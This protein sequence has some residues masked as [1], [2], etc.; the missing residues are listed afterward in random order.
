MEL[1][2]LVQDPCSFSL[3]MPSSKPLY[4]TSPP[5]SCTVGLGKNNN[6]CLA[7]RT[8]SHVQETG[9]DIRV[10]LPYSSIQQFFDHRNHFIIVIWWSWKDKWRFL[11]I[12]KQLALPVSVLRTAQPFEIFTCIHT[13]LAVLI[14]NRKSGGE[15][16]HNS[17]EYIG[18]NYFP[19]HICIRLNEREWT[20]VIPGNDSATCHTM[21]Y[22]WYRPS[23][24]FDMVIKSGPR[25]TPLTPS[26]LNS[27]LRKQKTTLSSVLLCFVRHKVKLEMFFFLNLG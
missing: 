19:F 16:V 13:R 22:T 1:G 23:C 9:A 4:R 20:E 5:S 8:Q 18:L 27:C 11:G 6:T 2:Q 25:S 14:D 3:T 12:H 7:K 24:T 26:I 21:R 15:K 17:S 10:Q